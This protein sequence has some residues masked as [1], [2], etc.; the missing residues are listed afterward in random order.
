MEYILDRKILIFVSK[1]GSDE[2]DWI[3]TR[4]PMVWFSSI[5]E[6][7]ICW[8]MD[9]KCMVQIS[10]LIY[11]DLENICQISK[12][13]TYQVIFVT[14]N[15]NYGIDKYTSIICCSLNNVSLVNSRT[16]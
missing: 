6:C 2:L 3:P 7:E 9:I 4:I 12:Y 10:Q 13:N 1:W 14:L 5:S 16:R 15:K 8:M 11:D